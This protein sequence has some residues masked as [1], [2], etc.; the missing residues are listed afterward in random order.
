MRTRLMLSAALATLLAA[1]PVMAQQFSSLEERMSAA[2]FKAAGLDKLSPQELQFLDDW[3]RTHGQAGTLSAGSQPVFHPDNQPRDK[4]DAHLT[5]HFN[6]WTGQ[7]LFHLD[8]GQVWK[9]AEQG[10]YTCPD[11]DNPRVTIKP[12][13][14]G[15]WLMYVQ[16]CDQSVRV[17]RVQ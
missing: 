9:Q 11:V 16:Y 8:N 6:G 13:I 17:E 3:L 15:S 1:L 14:L 4:F 7:T 5:G 12:M 2:D 10:S